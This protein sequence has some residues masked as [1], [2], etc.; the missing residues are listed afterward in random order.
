MRI[1][2]GKK[3]CKISC[4]FPQ[5]VQASISNKVKNPSRQV[6]ILFYSAATF[7]LKKSLNFLLVSILSMSLKIVFCPLLRVV[8]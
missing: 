6:G 8:E 5:L 2:I 3:N 1:S 7:L 4:K